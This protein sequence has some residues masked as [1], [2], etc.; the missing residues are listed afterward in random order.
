MN[1]EPTPGHI[2]IRPFWGLVRQR[3]TP[4]VG[5]SRRSALWG[6]VGPANQYR[7]RSCDVNQTPP[8]RSTRSR[9]Q[10][11]KESR[12][13]NLYWSAGKRPISKRREISKSTRADPFALGPRAY[14]RL[15]EERGLTCFWTVP[16]PSA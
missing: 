4:F 7:F 11:R 15:H 13:N 16:R 9:G 12:V 8:P 6:P 5:H 3:E 1:S 14:C 10:F 2:A